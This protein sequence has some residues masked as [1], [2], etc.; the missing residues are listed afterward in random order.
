MSIHTQGG[1][2]VISVLS[3]LI[4][5]FMGFHASRKIRFVLASVCIVIAMELYQRMDEIDSDGSVIA[6]AN[7][8]PLLL[9]WTPI[10]ELR[11]GIERKGR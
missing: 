7:D 8:L 5:G 9:K 3:V 6:L 4:D 1:G 2:I 10:D 11:R